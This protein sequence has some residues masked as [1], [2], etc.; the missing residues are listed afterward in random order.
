MKVAIR[1][2][3]PLKHR[4]RSLPWLFCLHCRRRLVQVDVVDNRTCVPQ[5]IGVYATDITLIC[6][7]GQKRRFRSVTIK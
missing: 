5:A 6:D 4:R 3:P 2:W 1:I 7:C